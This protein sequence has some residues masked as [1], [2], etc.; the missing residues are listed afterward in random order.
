MR[1]I[2]I[3]ASIIIFT[4]GFGLS[5]IAGENDEIKET[6]EI[7]PLEELQAASD[8]FHNLGIGEL[9]TDIKIIFDPSGEFKKEDIEKWNIP[10]SKYILL[11][12]YYYKEGGIFQCKVFGEVIARNDAETAGMQSTIVVPLIPMPGGIMCGDAVLERYSVSYKGEFI[13]DGYP[14]NIIKLEAINSDDEFFSFIE[15][16][17]DKKNKVIRKVE[18]AFELGYWAGSA[19]GE[20]FYKKKRGKLMPNIGHGTVYFR[21]PYSRLWIIWGKW[22]GFEM[23]SLDEINQSDEDAEE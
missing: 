17:I 5:S 11:S 2:T 20:F 3:I 4:F 13:Q 21:K 8:Y 15:Y 1:V 10:K 22:S 14:C 19:E 6:P 9:D 18:C 7:N 12:H 16:Y 23:K